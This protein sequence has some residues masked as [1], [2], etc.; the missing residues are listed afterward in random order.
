[1]EEKLEPRLTANR[2][3]ERVDNGKLIMPARMVGDN[4]GCSKCASND[5]PRT[6]L[7]QFSSREALAA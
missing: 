6:S 1:M 4:D 7:A 2:L 5:D 3:S